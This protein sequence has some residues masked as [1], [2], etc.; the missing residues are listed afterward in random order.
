MGEWRNLEEK[1][2]RKS[3]SWEMLGAVCR[4]RRERS[5]SEHC[6]GR[7]GGG[8]EEAEGGKADEG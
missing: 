7:K 8:E 3:G 1:S 4:Q 6:E 2:K 5:E